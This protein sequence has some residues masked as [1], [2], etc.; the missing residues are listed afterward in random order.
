MQDCLPFQP[1]HRC[2]TRGL[3]PLLLCLASALVP[4]DVCAQS[5]SGWLVKPSLMAALADDDNI[6]F[7]QTDP[8]D[9]RVLRVSPAIEAGYRTAPT[10][11]N[12]YYMLDALRYDRFS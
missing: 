3:I 1:E 10:A 5:D 4:Q 12:A 8:Q 9:D 7:E 2:T 11:F 6:F